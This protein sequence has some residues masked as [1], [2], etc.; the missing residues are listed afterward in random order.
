ML[1]IYEHDQEMVGA[2]APR[3]LL[4]LQNIDEK[5]WEDAMSS[6]KEKL[7]QREQEW[8]DSVA[9]LA[10]NGSEAVDA[11]L[12]ALSQLP[13]NF[14]LKTFTDLLMFSYALVFGY[15]P[16]EFWTVNTGV[17]GRGNETAI[18]HNKA[19][20]KGGLDFILS[21]QDRLQQVIPETVLF[22]FEQ[23]DVGGEL[24]SA[25]LSKA[26]AEVA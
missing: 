7:T 2:K 25:Q 11:K 24:D 1:G 3:G 26:W 15:D 10:Q 23:R 16:S 14:D 12:I 13:A 22:E 9:V 19:T 4:I 5:Q 8:F 18:Q 6:R 21:Y 17:L 20:G